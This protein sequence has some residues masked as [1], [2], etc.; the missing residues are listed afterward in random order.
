M[1]RLT[2]IFAT[3]RPLL[4]STVTVIAKPDAQA[5]ENGA[6][7]TPPMGWNTWN[8]FGRNISESLIR[9]MADAM[10]SSGMACGTRPGSPAR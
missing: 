1:R 8:T 4:A 9:Q 7:R 2:T 5:L 10:V 3:G 6:A